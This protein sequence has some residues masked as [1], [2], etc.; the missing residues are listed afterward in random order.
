MYS[1]ELPSLHFR[2]RA[3]CEPFLCNNWFGWEVQVPRPTGLL[4]P[5][6]SNKQ[7]RRV[8]ETDD[9]EEQVLVEGLVF[10]PIEL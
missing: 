8:L 2:E 5:D 10:S 9:L 4:R 1:W 7:K 6:G 3:R